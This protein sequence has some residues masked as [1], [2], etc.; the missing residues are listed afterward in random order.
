MPTKNKIVFLSR[1]SDKPSLDFK[2]IEEEIRKIDENIEIVYVTKRIVKSKIEVLKNFGTILKSMKQLATSK[3]CITDGY[4]IA[5]SNLKHK[6]Y[7]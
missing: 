1:Q 2:R 7:G 3:I 4:N 6:E 5:I